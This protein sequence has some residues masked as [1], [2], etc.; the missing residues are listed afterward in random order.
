VITLSRLAAHVGGLKTPPH[1]PFAYE[2]NRGRHGLFGSEK[3]G[4][5]WHIEQ[6]RNISIYLPN[7]SNQKV[8]GVLL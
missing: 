6:Y 7:K 8:S 1:P 3:T 2:Y 4:R 5:F